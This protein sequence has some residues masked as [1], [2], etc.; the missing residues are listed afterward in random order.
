[1][2]FSQSAVLRSSPREGADILFVAGQEL[3]GKALRR[4]S[5]QE[6]AE[7]IQSQGRLSTILLMRL[8]VARNREDALRVLRMA[9]KRKATQR[10]HSSGKGRPKRQPGPGILQQHARM[11]MQDEWFDD[12]MWDEM[13]WYPGWGDDNDFQ[14]WQ[15]S[16]TGGQLTGLPY[17]PLS[18][19]QERGLQLAWQRR[20]QPDDHSIRA[21]IGEETYQRL[22]AMSGAREIILSSE[23]EEF[24]ALHDLHHLLEENGDKSIIDGFGLAGLDIL[25]RYGA[26]TGAFSVAWM[27]VAHWYGQRFQQEPDDSYGWLV[28][29]LHYF[30]AHSP[31]AAALELLRRFCLD[32]QVHRAWLPL[33][34]YFL[35]RL[36]ELFPR[37]RLGPLSA[38]FA[39]NWESFLLESIGSLLPL[40][41]MRET[42]AD[43]LSDRLRAPTERE[44]ALHPLLV[45]GGG[46]LRSQDYPSFTLTARPALSLVAP[47]TVTAMQE[48]TRALY[49]GVASLRRQ[50]SRAVSD[51]LRLA[52][53]Q[54][55]TPP[56]RWDAVWSPLVEHATG[57]VLLVQWVFPDADF[58]IRRKHV[59]RFWEQHAVGEL[60]VPSV[61][62]SLELLAHQYGVER[63]I[64]G[65]V[66]G[67]LS[68]FNERWPTADGQEIS[69]KEPFIM[70][71][72]TLALH[73]RSGMQ[74]EHP[75]HI[76]PYNQAP[77]LVRAMADL[78]LRQSQHAPL[79]LAQA[80]GIG[81]EQGL[82]LLAGGRMTE[83]EHRVRHLLREAAGGVVRRDESQPP[84][85]FTCRPLR[86]ATALERGDLG[87]DCSSQAVPLRATSPHHIYYGIWEEGVQQRGY[88]T[89]FECWAEDEEKVQWPALCLETINVPIPIFDA[90]Q[91]DLLL[92]FD[93]I[94]RSRGLHT[95]IVLTTGY[96]T[97]NYQ[98]GTLLR[99]SRRFR[100]G[101]A[102]TLHPAD[103][104]HWQLYSRMTREAGMYSSFNQY[105]GGGMIR[106]LAPFDPERDTVQPEN[107]AEAERLA[108]LPVGKPIPTI[109]AG[110]KTVG[111]ISSWPAP[112][113]NEGDP[114]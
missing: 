76:D 79:E 54:T 112:L 12:P 86:K 94:A 80:L 17:P 92:I 91:E 31:A 77:E 25:A 19:L 67:L 114:V 58:R 37:L 73:Y 42:L 97:W 28:G 56:L 81:H 99:H 113:P 82:P 68:L 93:A 18:A 85:L 51:L 104:V 83:W 103:P 90:V 105:W 100:Q 57:Y 61:P 48:F 108:G 40:V 88:M 65:L 21:V 23:E 1:M 107:L 87:G 44:P 36:A 35:S 9:R 59:R 3:V 55:V 95:P 62:P 60:T 26:L 84:R 53:D 74:D 50:P 52:L 47:Q 10:S 111:F 96:G 109:Q 71:L 63:L 27:A 69:L 43:L 89:V 34:P 38:E 110:G 5:W 22:V 49:Q 24:F 15:A 33:L 78:L 102:V 32:T 70:T 13:M 2:R 45:V 64:E 29:S 46:C 6:I 7:A 14:E 39:A 30:V 106:T 41:Q 16:Q 20:R 11:V 66:H 75:P 72:R 98:N 101:E 8:R 4:A